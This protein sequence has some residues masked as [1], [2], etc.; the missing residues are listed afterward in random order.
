MNSPTG[1]KESDNRT[2]GDPP[3]AAGLSVDIEERDDMLV[4]TVR[5]AL[6][7]F[8]TGSLQQQLSTALNRGTP[9][10]VLDLEAVTFVDST[11]LALL[12]SIRRRVHAAGGWLRLANPHI[13]PRRALHTTNLDK[14]FEVYHS[15]DS[16]TTTP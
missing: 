7:F 13:Q 11:G 15:V 14:Y 8:S 4:A 9:K 6:D 10:L 2:G 1:D 12:V 5:G 3:G 16:A